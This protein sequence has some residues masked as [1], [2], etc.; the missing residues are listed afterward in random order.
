MISV[1]FSEFWTHVSLLEII[2]A[3]LAGVQAGVF[4]AWSQGLG[5]YF[6][7]SAVL[8]ANF[9]TA[10]V[11]SSAIVN[12]DNWEDWIGVWALWLTFQL[13]VTLGYKLRRWW[14]RRSRKAH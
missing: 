7:H 6:F 11:V 12:R 2:V 3:L 8:S 4:Y 14:S 5:T 9:F 1:D 13:G 10:I